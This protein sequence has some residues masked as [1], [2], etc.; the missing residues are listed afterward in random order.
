MTAVPG[1]REAASVRGLSRAGL[2]LASEIQG[3]ND[4]ETP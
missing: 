4:P 2:S 3:L 1:G